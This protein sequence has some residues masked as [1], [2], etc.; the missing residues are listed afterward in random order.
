MARDD[1]IAKNVGVQ[2]EVHTMPGNVV[3]MMDW[4]QNNWNQN[5]CANMVI[6][7]VRLFLTHSYVTVVLTGLRHKCL[8][9]LGLC[10]V[11]CYIWG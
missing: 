11:N 9:C 6:G 5:N 8:L 1:M 10:T 4:N 7:L 2:L 3:M